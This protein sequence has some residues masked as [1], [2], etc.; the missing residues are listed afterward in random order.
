MYCLLT[1]RSFWARW[2]ACILLA[3]TASVRLRAQ[4][5]ED[6]PIGD[7]AY[8]YL[9]ALLARGT[10]QSLSAL[11]RPYN[12]RQIV[13]AL[14]T[15]VPANPSRAVRGY[16][17]GLRRALAK[18]DVERLLSP[19]PQRP[20]RNTLNWQIGGT[21]G[22]TFQTSSIRDLMRDNDIH[23]E[24]ADVGLQGA[25][26]VGPVTAVIHEVLEG[27]LNVDP[28]YQ[29][30][31]LRSDA[32]RTNEGYVD[33]RWP[34]FEVFLGRELRNWGPTMMPGLLLGDAA[35]S[36]DH[37]YFQLG[38]PQ[39]HWQFLTTR[40]NN[41][42]SGDTTI[43]R[44]F[45]IH[46]IATHI[47]HVEVGVEES[48]VYGGAGNSYDFHYLSPFNVYT[49]SELNEEQGGVGA[50]KN[51]SIEAAWRSKVGTFSGQFYLDDVQIDNKCTPQVLCDKPW[52]GGWTLAAEGIPFIGDQRLFASYTLV[53]N[54]SYRT[55]EQPWT[56]YTSYG[57][58]L[59]RGFSDYDEWKAGV[60]LAV[61]PEV[62]LKVYGAYSRQGQGSYR[63]PFPVPDSFPDTPWFLSGIVAHVYRGAV[64][65]AVSL[66]WLDVSGDVGIDHVTNYQ[67]VQGQ[68]HTTLSGR[69]QFSLVWARIFGGA[70][71]VPGSSD[72]DGQPPLERPRPPN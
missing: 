32:V 49:F 50:N 22:G 72:A 39:V 9:D 31:F 61:I 43:N 37:L 3:L 40:L 56:D 65:G 55:Y 53:T 48:V 12:L 6:V 58:G 60:D 66:S 8:V 67:N 13:R 44:Y 63:Y 69:V 1:R 64:S 29:D 26:A 5:A 54:L 68:S 47:G 51:Y 62:P 25:M 18:Y 19:P 71:R 16:I 33:A 14:Q 52:S 23:G 2:A 57:V 20:A 28:Q 7:N 41:E 38:I 17:R 46:R 45:T 10:L 21:A 24:F 59:G 27:Q 15:E 35:Y 34:I 42:L 30:G 4:A 11:E 36:Y 70:I